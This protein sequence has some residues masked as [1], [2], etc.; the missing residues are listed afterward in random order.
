MDTAA[1][2][3]MEGKICLVTGATSGI[4]FETARGLAHSG[5]TVVLAGR[6]PDKGAAA[7]HSIRER[8]SSS[9][10]EYLNADLSSQAEV[11]KLASAF[12]AA[13]NRLDVLVNDAGAAYLRH[14]RSV[15]GIEKTF[16]VN[17]LSVFLLTNLLLDTLKASAPSRIII[18][19]SGSHRDARIH[20]DDLNLD[21]GYWVMRAYGQSKLAN[22]LFTYELARRLEGTGVTA[23]AVHPGWVRTNIGRNNGWLVQL[24]MPLLQFGARP[25]E[26]G[27]QTP[28]YLATSSDVAGVSG[29]YWIDEQAVPSSSASYDEAAAFRLWQISAEMTGL[30]QYP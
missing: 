4:G 3:T 15:D 7:L 28:L 26:E 9:Q 10:L 1:D 17:H 2:H 21:Q 19:S 18:V 23:N 14:Q 30:E 25:A 29:K 13:H 6:N 16:A 20:F 27:A 5:A 24:L 8:T 11:R 22:L 12:L